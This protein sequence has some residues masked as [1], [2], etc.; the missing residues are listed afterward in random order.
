MRQL[1]ASIRLDNLLV[2]AFVSRFQIVFDCAELALRPGHFLAPDG[3][4]GIGPLDELTCAANDYFFQQVEDAD[5][6]FFD[7]LAPRC[8]EILIQVADARRCKIGTVISGEQI[9]LVVEIEDVVVDW[10]GRQQDQLF[11][12]AV[13]TSPTI[14]REN[15]F[16]LLTLR[17]LVT[18]VMRLVDENHIDIGIISHVE[19]SW[20]RRSCV[21]TWAAIALS[22]VLLPTC[23]LSEAG[24]ITSA[25]CR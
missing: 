13:A 7:E 15:I 23:R 6:A 11:A 18:E 25:F 4:F 3:R 24:Q 14:G 20:P 22:A 10:R 16:K 5:A 19:S 12:P 2:E 9:D 1:Q 21:T 8:K 17:P